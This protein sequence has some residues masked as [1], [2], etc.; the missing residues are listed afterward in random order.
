MGGSKMSLGEMVMV[1]YTKN[2]KTNHKI[3]YTK[4]D[5]VESCLNRLHSDNSSTTIFIPHV[6][7]NINL[8]GAGFAKYI[9]DKFPVV[10]EN[11]HL[12]GNKAILGYTQYIRVSSN[13]SNKTNI[14]VCNMIAQ[15]G[16]INPKNSR[17]LNYSSLVFC[18]NDIKNKL[19]SLAQ[20]NIND[21]PYEIHAPKFGSGLA[22][23]NWNFIENIIED[24][25]S[26]FPVYVYIK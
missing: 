18:M 8:F 6:C 26:D 20:N 13:K 2:R 9:G 10:K 7:N 4:K 24:I 25:W 15:N 12:L 23:G 17:P 11:F 16:T 1:N 5:I 3:I 21:I 22:G 14:F 19:I